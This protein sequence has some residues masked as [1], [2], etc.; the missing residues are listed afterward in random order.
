MTTFEQKYKINE[1][2]RL[3]VVWAV[4]K[5]RNYVNGT[6]F[7]VVSDHKAVT[8]ISKGNRANRTFS[9]R[10]TRCVD[11]LL[12]FQFIVTHES[13]CT[14]GL[15][16]YLS[17]HPSPSNV[18]NQ[19]KA[20][21]F[22]NDW[23]TFNEIKRKKPVVDEQKQIGETNKPIAGKLA[24]KA[25]HAKMEKTA[26]EKDDCKQTKQTLKSL[27]DTI[28]VDESDSKT[29]K[30]SSTDS[31]NE[32]S[33]IEFANIPPLKTPICY[34][35]NQVE[36]LQALGNYTFAANFESDE[37][38]QKILKPIETPDTTKIN[39]LPAPWRENFRYFSRGSNDYLLRDERLVVLKALRPIILQSSH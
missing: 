20:E 13:G 16:D 5:F 23:F 10:L 31:E 3:T 38:L 4:E 22:W 2:Q 34:S 29:D 21:T 12:P 30:I 24:E 25:E 27:I 18:K 17:R 33:T 1:L 6:E 7:E 8:S 39:R 15:V 37:F 9:S 35:I 14:L 28:M 32:T 11:R 36:I 26:S 19:I